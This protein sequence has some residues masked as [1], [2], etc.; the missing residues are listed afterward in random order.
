MHFLRFELTPEMIAALKYGVGVA[1]GVD[2]PAYT[3]TLPA[4][5]TRRAAR[6][7]PIS[8]SRRGSARA[9]LAG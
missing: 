6:W 9:S 7:S 1:I 2:H 8:P 5:P 3:F 4:V